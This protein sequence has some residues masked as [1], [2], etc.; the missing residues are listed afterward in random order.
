MLVT[1]AAGAAL[2]WFGRKAWL[3]L[4]RQLVYFCQTKLVP[5]MKKT[6]GQTAGDVLANIVYYIDNGVVFSAQAVRAARAWLRAKLA[7]LTTSYVKVGP[8]TV[9]RSCETI[10]RNDD[11]SGEC[12][13]ETRKLD[14]SELPPEIRA[15]IRETHAPVVI[16]DRDVLLT[17]FDEKAEENGVVLELEY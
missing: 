10:L 16:D 15:K 2:A 7:K 9:E 14:W 17:R 8:S 4:W 6:F 13:V 1:L 3:W 12:R 5:W 11:G